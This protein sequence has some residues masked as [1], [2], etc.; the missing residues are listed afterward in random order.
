[1][2]RVP[3]HHRPLAAPRLF[4][5]A[6]AEHFQRTF[7]MSTA[8]HVVLRQGNA[9]LLHRIV[10]IVFHL[11]VEHGRVVQ[12]DGSESHAARRRRLTHQTLGVAPQV[13]WAPPERRE[14]APPE[15][16]ET[17]LVGQPSAGWGI[18]PSVGWECRGLHPSAGEPFWPYV[19]SRARDGGLPH[20]RHASA[21]GVGV[22]H[23][24]IEVL[25]T[26]HSS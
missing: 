26:Y 11:L 24:D 18:Q 13:P 20:S 1:M 10:V 9:A 8:V 15:R 22:P 21:C 23:Q 16:R 19:Y 6:I 3:N 17:V 2:C 14:R 25:L 7:R 12:F 4:A 5:P